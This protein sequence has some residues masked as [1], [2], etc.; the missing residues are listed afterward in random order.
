MSGENNQNKEKE[1]KQNNLLNI[2]SFSMF[3]PQKNNQEHKIQLLNKSFEENN[4]K[5]F[6]Q[7][8]NSIYSNHTSNEINLDLEKKVCKALFETGKFKELI[9]FLIKMDIFSQPLSSDDVVY[10]Q[11]TKALTFE[12]LKMYKKALSTFN[13]LIKNF[14]SNQVIGNAYISKCQLFI[15]TKKYNNAL[16]SL[17]KSLDYDISTNIFYSFLSVILF[18]MENNI[19]AK[20]IL[21]A[22]KLLDNKNDINF[23]DYFFIAK[24]SYEIGNIYKENKIYAIAIKYFKKTIKCSKSPKQRTI[25]YIGIKNCYAM[26]EQFYK[27]RGYTKLVIKTT[28]SKTLKLKYLQALSSFYFYTEEFEKSRQICIELLSYPN[29]FEKSFLY[30]SIAINEFKQGKLKEA[31]KTISLAKDIETK[32]NLLK[33]TIDEYYAIIVEKE[34]ISQIKE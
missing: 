7:I 2:I 20:K 33:E 6:L 19:L 23:K 10:F 11:M 30:A 24:I 28:N 18:K 8:Y 9:K 26:Q 34:E 4:F 14:S 13:F 21:Q 5:K 32:S 29:L 27:A 12:K 25:C 31:Q 17:F 22:R 3:A 15:V 16:K 1:K